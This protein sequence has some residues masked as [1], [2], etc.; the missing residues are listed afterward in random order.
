MDLTA[1]ERQLILTLR[2]LQSFTV[3]IA[4][5]ILL[6]NGDAGRTEVG[7][8]VDLR[9]AWIDLSDQRSDNT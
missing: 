8:G 3:G 5:G 9:S 7:D 4:M 2:H 1:P 6:A